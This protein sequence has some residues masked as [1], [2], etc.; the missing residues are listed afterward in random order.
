VNPLLFD[1]DPKTVL[2]GLLTNVNAQSRNVGFNI[3][4]SNL[5]NTVIGRLNDE[6]TEIADVEGN[7]REL[8]NLGHAYDNLVERRNSVA[9]FAFVNESNKDRLSDLTSLATSAIL[10]FGVGDSDTENISAD[11]LSNLETAKTDILA[12][13]DRLVELSHAEFI[14][15]NN[16]TRVRSLVDDLINLTATEGV[17]DDEGTDPATNENRAILDKLAEI[18]VATGAASDTSLTLQHASTQMVTNFDRKLSN[19]DSEMKT[20]NA[21]R[22]VEIEFEIQMLRTKHATFLR[23]IEIAF[24]ANAQATDGLANALDNNQE[25][26]LGSILSILT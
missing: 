2:N 16:I 24:D 12:M 4:F 17:L 15:G 5:Q 13:S 11:E 25:P 23:S 3:A 10:N 20:I 7:Q 14:D 19:I 22:S 9:G 8:D 6:I 18:V 1:V 21:V 26:P